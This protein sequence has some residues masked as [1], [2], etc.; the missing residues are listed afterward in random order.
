[1]AKTLTYAEYISFK[2]FSSFTYV[3]NEMMSRHTFFRGQQHLFGRKSAVVVQFRMYTTG[4]IML[5]LC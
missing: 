3:V 1:M 4:L 5:F 2:N